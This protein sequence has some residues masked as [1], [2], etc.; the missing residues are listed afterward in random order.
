[1]ELFSEIKR[2]DDAKTWAAKAS[3]NKNANDPNKNLVESI[4]KDQAESIRDTGEWA[5]AANLFLECKEYR[6]AIEIYGQHNDFDRLIAICRS[7]DK[8]DNLEAI[9]MCANIFRK[10][11]NHQHAKEAY[12]KLGDLKALMTLHI[13]LKRWDEAFMLA[14][15]N[16]DFKQMIHAPY[17]EYLEENNLF[18]E[19]QREYKLAKRPDLSMRI[20]EKLS[21]NAITESRFKDAGTFYWLLALENVQL[22]KNMKSLSDIKEA[23]NIEK[24][25]ECCLLADLYYAY[26][27]VHNF[28][29]EPF[30]SITDGYF[31]KV[32]N[33]ARFIL[34][35][36]DTRSP[37]GV[38]ASYKY[39]SKLYL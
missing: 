15:Q 36:I 38:I 9:Q 21:L 10:K 8:S 12:L 23:K 18:E 25:K 27:I 6:K 37:V 33:A 7:L 35:K 2:W 13:E 1:M 24:Y 20:V 30:H 14:K 17:A 5:A 32:F 26:S 3:K 31:L 39:V 29:E 28:I 16:P 4:I 34:G 11:G 22:V 19:A